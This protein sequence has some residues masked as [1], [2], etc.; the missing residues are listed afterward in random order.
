MPD[1]I[2]RFWVADMDFKSPPRSQAL[3]QILHHGIFDTAIPLM[4]TI[5]MLCSAGIK[6]GLTG[7]SSLNGCEIAR[8]TLPSVLAIRALTK[9]EMPF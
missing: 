1:D 5:S 7:I 3:S 6:T 2:L 4:K 9:P 8:C